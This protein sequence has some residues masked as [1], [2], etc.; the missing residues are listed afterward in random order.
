M[1]FFRDYEKISAIYLFIRF[2]YRTFATLKET[3]NRI[4]KHLK[5]FAY[6]VTKIFYQEKAG[7][8]YIRNFPGSVFA[9]PPVDECDGGLFD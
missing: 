9:V 4:N 5:Q 7:D 3:L 8:E 1:I 2:L 6:V